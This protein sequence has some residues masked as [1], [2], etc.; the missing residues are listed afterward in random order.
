MLQRDSGR[1]SGGNADFFAARWQFAKKRKRETQAV[2][3]RWCIIFWYTN[4]I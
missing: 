2:D 4:E 3:F 1:F